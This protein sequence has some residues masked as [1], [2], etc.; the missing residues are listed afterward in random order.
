MRVTAIEC[1]GRIAA[2]ESLP[3]LLDVLTTGGIASEG[4]PAQTAAWHALAAMP[5]EL[6]GPRLVDDLA[7]DP[8]PRADVLALLVE[9]REPTAWEPLAK[10]ALAQDPAPWQAAIDSL[11]RLARP[12]AADL[13]RL[14]DLYCATT[15]LQR[16]EAVSRMIATV[17]RH[18]EG[19]E[20]ASTVI[21]A[22]DR[23]GVA[24]ELT[25]PLVGR[26]GGVA[27]LNGIDSALTSP[28]PRVREAA[29]EG[30]C[31]WPDASV[32]ERMLAIARDCLPQPERRAGWHCGP[33]CG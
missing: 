16:R 11:G 13:E 15:A 33:M 30:L 2:G 27:A 4:S 19:D 29:F 10:L 7:A 12:Q 24:A 20:A 31:N 3:V 17:S 28:N 14:V 9:L 5:R 6:V 25:L 18:V 22:V 23:R 26:L 21:A 32:A 8:A 1:L